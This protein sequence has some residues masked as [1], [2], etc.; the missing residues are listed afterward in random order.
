MDKSKKMNRQTIFTLAGIGVA[1][2][3]TTIGLYWYNSRHK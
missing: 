3:A 1:A 2:A